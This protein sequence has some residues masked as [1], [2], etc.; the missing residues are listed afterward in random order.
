MNVQ[1]CI[2][3]IDGKIEWTTHDLPDV[4][5][6][7][8]V[9]RV[10]SPIIPD[11]EHVTVLWQDKRTD[12]FIDELGVVKGLPINAFATGVYYTASIVAGRQISP[13]PICGPAVLFNERIWF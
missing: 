1:R 12:M 10:V 6:Y 8:D 5:E 13:N 9:K 7:D 3:H 2:I 11:F 4:P